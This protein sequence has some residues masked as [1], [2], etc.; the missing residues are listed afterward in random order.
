MLKSALV[1]ALVLVASGALCGCE[2]LEIAG[3]QAPAQPGPGVVFTYPQDGQYDVPI[4]AQLVVTWSDETP[5]PPTLSLENE[6]GPVPIQTT[7]QGRS[8]LVTA[9]LEENST[10]DL[11]VNGVAQVTFHT[12]CLTP[13]AKSP[14]ELLTLNE[15]PVDNSSV[16]DVG[17]LRLLFS[18][19]LDPSTINASTVRLVAPN[20]GPVA[21][22]VVSQGP[23]LTFSPQAKLR[24]DVTYELQLSEDIKDL[25]GEAAL[26]TSF[27]IVPQATDQGYEQTLALESAAKPESASFGEPSTLSAVPSNATLLT[28]QLIGSNVLALQPASLQA[29]LWDPAEHGGAIPFTIRRGQRIDVDS[30]DIFLGGQVS[31]GVSTGTLHFTLLTDAFGTLSRSPYRS[32][33]QPPDDE[34]APVFADI[35]MDAAVT[36]EDAQG[37]VIATQNVLGIRL[38]G[39]ATVTE[40]YMVIELVGSFDYDTLGVGLATNTIALRLVSGSPPVAQQ[41]LPTPTL[42]SSYPA[43]G[44][45]DFEADQVL[46]ANYTGPIDPASLGAIRLDHAGSAIPIATW[47]NGSVVLIK[48]ATRLQD[49]AQGTLTLEGL[50]ALDGAPIEA[51]TLEFSTPDLQFDS[52]EAPPMV[53][54][55]VPGAPCALKNGTREAPGA[56]QGGLNSDAS[57]QPFTH[58]ANHE[59]RVWFSQPMDVASV[60][61]GDI[62]GEGSV[63]VETL[64][65]TGNCTAAVPGTLEVS[66]RGF[67][68]RPSSALQVGGTYRF[69][70]VSGTD[71]ACDPGELCSRSQLPLNTTPLGGLEAE[72]AGGP[73]IVIEFEATA[74]TADNFQP[75]ESSPQSDLNGNGYLDSQEAPVVTNQVAYEIV[76]VGGVI[77]E[78]SLNGAD[79]MPEREGTQVCVA[80]H[81]TLPVDIQQLLSSCPIDLEGNPSSA[82]VPCIQTHLFPTTLLFSSL[83]MNTTAL[84]LVPVNDLPTGHVFVRIQEL[85]GP[86][87][88][89]IVPDPESD[90]PQYVINNDVYIDA[91]DMSI[92]DGLVPHDLQSKPLQTTLRGP[93]TFRPDGRMDVALRST[94]DLTIT[95]NISVLGLPGHVVLRIPAG[96]M[97]VT[98][99]GPMLR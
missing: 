6:S 15:A 90:I 44:A 52:I 16:L 64:D 87:Y 20:T 3:S 60:A 57:Y 86:S 84:G 17:T 30:L 83:S 58:P 9:P 99:G 47:V 26:A 32:A 25:G 39:V 68:F 37:N 79:C 95:V 11:L 53:L 82:A 28:S 48:P 45:P 75:L 92:L 27:A 94:R 33:D 35:V 31:Q 67:G 8:Q 51:T 72:S 85:E 13:Q 21:G 77:T 54:G 63:R 97:A 65:E 43:Q 49:G 93:V 12:S 74:N 19:P 22:T 56:C 41:P 46:E 98:L 89:Y 14:P 76:D 18:E 66:E 69:T 29:Q 10:Y 78:A 50:Q 40:D 34:R 62:C 88:G 61:L 7:Q 59:L 38:A 24:S 36:S 5:A 42:Y 81:A 1:L 73:D 96:A 4:H 71:T 91:P 80:V 23:H 70:L 55:V 2:P